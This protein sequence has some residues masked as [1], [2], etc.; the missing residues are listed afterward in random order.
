MSTKTRCRQA[1]ASLIEAIFAAALFAVV[2]TIVV[3]AL[4][5][6]KVMGEQAERLAHAL[7]LAAS[8][9]EQRRMGGASAAP[10][11]SGGYE[12][13]VFSQ[14]FAGH[15][16][17]EEVTAEVSWGAPDRRRVHLRTLMFRFPQDG[18]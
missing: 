11:E 8:A 15:P 12:Q 1:G 9:I 10:V 14:P 5:Q 7:L 2:S 18:G 4:S 13:Q 6:A 3:L 16:Q 17:L